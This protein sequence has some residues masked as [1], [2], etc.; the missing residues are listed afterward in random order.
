MELKDLQRVQVGGCHLNKQDVFNHAWSKGCRLFD[1]GWGYSG[2]GVNDVAINEIISKNHKREDFMICQKFPMYDKLYQEE[3]GR[4]IRDLDDKELAQV[5]DR[6]F[7]TQCQRCNTEYFDIYML[8]AIYDNKYQ[9]DFNIKDETDFYIRLLT[10]FEKLKEKG[11]IKHIG[12]SSHNTYEM[13]YYFISNV[14]EK[15]G[16]IMDVAEVSYNILNDCGKSKLGQLYDITIWP[17]AGNEG[18]KLLKEE[19]FFIIDMMPTEGG[20][21]FELSQQPTW[22]DWNFRF[23]RDNPN[24]DIVLCGTSS[25]KHFDEMW[26][27]IVEE[28]DLKNIPD[29]RK[30]EGANKHCTE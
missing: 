9:D 15:L 7:Y 14:K 18:L 16:K 11:K 17:A 24:I 10:V 30:I 3:F 26:D 20:R 29:M 27:I 2:P 4:S 21:I 23:I 13:L 25:T 19:G 12:F 8:H 28:K 5:V 1:T 6:V 22:R